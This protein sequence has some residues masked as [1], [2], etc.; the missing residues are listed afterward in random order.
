M[1]RSRYW[2]VALYVVHV[3]CLVLAGSAAAYAEDQAALAQQL[4][5]RDQQIQTLQEKIRQLERDQPGPAMPQQSAAVTNASGMFAVDAV[6]AE[7]ALE[8]T[9]TRSGALLLPAGQAELQFGASYAHSGQQT[10]ALI[11]QDGQLGIGTTTL[12]RHDAGTS[13]AARVGLPSDTQFD[14]TLPYRVIR[15]SVIEPVD[16]S[17]VRETR[18]AST[19]VGDLSFGLAKT[20]MREQ[21]WR[22]DL[23][24]RIGWTVG[25]GKEASGNIQVGDGFR[26]IRGELTALK[27][28][29]P[30]VWTANLSYESTFKK[31]AFQPGAQVGLSLSALLAASP[32]SSLSVG[33]DQTFSGSTRIHGVSVAGS[34]QRA[35]VLTLGA[36][37]LIGRNTL[38]S[39]SAGIG[40]TRNTPDYVINV[41]LPIRFDLFN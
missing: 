30:L 39:L 22:P 35:G 29:D 24:G 5:Q 7:H 15:Q 11:A 34:D 9:L 40:L 6:A 27:R 18:T 19:S 41:A 37:S 23:I 2:P 14:V 25:N 17:R 33:F 13:V 3:L 12:R 16:F 32:E 36:T 38:L 10:P 8:R 21:D 20:L 28:Q 26:K 4:R 1:N 31:G